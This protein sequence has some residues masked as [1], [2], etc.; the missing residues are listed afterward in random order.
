ML[1]LLQSRDGYRHAAPMRVRR[2]M[3]RPVEQTAAR[4]PDVRRKPRTKT[5]KKEEKEK[6]AKE[7][8]QERKTR[9]DTIPSAIRKEKRQD[10][11][12]KNTRNGHHAT[13]DTTPQNSITSRGGIV[14]PCK[15]PDIGG[16]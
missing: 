10:T 2:I 12:T 14:F 5:T 16:A 6:R 3:P 11:D 8:K 15:K 13:A 9:Y 7:E 1:L 4:P